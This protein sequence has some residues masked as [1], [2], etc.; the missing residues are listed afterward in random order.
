MHE[1]CLGFVRRERGGAAVTT[2][3]RGGAQRMQ[4]VVQCKQAAGRSQSGRQPA[5]QAARQGHAKGH[6]MQTCDFRMRCKHLQCTRT[7]PHTHTQHS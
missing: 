4:Q 5:Q 7:H 3:G 1:N 2:G 6:I